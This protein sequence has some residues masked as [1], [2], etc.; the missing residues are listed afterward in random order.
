MTLRLHDNCIDFE[1]QTKIYELCASGIW[2]FGKAAAPIGPDGVGE[3]SHANRS[4][5]G[6]NFDTGFNFWNVKFKKEQGLMKDLW[7]Q[8]EERIVGND[9]VTVERVYGNA[10]TYGMEGDVHRD[11][12]H[13]TFMFMPC[14]WSHKW[15]GGTGFFDAEGTQ[16]GVVP[17]REGRV[18]SFPARLP[19]ASLPIA[20]LCNTARYVIVYKTTINGYKQGDRPIEHLEFLEDK[21]NSDVQ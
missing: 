12:G 13:W 16:V 21:K 1:L 19:H 8:I 11:D 2:H 18:I 10:I 3:L 4:L 7:D 9:V 15:G 5:Q 6:D 17:Y 14:A 20:R